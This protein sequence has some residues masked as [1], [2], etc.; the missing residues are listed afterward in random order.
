MEYTD[1]LRK[2]VEERVTD[3]VEDMGDKAPAELKGMAKAHLIH[4]LTSS[5]TST[6][7]GMQD[8]AIWSACYRLTT[9]I[10]WAKQNKGS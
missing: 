4:E 1:Y 2:H 7:R 9:S 8:T 6:L 5:A 10:R 3:F